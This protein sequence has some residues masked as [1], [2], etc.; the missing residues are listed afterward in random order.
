MNFKD[1]FSNNS[2]QYAS[3]RPLY[4]E[5]LFKYLSKISPSN[6]LAWDC[7]TGN[8]QAALGL[9]SHFES[10]IATD[11]SS[12]QINFAMKRDN[13]NYKVASAE[14]S[15][16]KG[17]SIDLVTV[18]TAV[19]WFDLNKFY[20]E[21]ERVCKKNGVLAT[22]IY[23]TKIKIDTSIDSIIENYLSLV[24]PFFPEEAQKNWSNGYDWID[25]PF[26]E[27]KAPEFSNTIKWS[28]EFLLEYIKSW[29]G[30]RRHME[31]NG[32]GPFDKFGDDLR[33]FWPS[34]KPILLHKWN[35]QTKIGFVNK[36]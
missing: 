33:K 17:N 36:V 28:S 22:W 16:L 12:K 18:A 4:P 29:S 1:H 35:I 13:I 26:E 9:S 7:A 10:V 30:S 24:M 6:T 23:D 11:A 3:S 5:K 21:V 2:S 32:T 19:H 14:M 27:I 15:N 31:L 8:G 25:F 20:K 34:N